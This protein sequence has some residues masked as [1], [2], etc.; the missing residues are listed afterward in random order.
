LPKN[1]LGKFRHQ[2]NKA[3][4]IIGCQKNGWA[5]LGSNQTGPKSKIVLEN[6][7][8]VLV[9][10]EIVPVEFGRVLMKSEVFRSDGELIMI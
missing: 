7:E 6:S 4:N 10:S 3:Q 2:P 9:E 5:N 8:I 1:W